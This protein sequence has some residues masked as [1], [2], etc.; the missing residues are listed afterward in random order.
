[1]D[2]RKKRLPI[3][4]KRIHELPPDTT[5]VPTLS[6]IKKMAQ[7][8][9]IPKGPWVRGRLVDE[10]DGTTVLKM[11][12]RT[13]QDCDG[14]HFYGVSEPI[15]EGRRTYRTIDIKNATRSCWHNVTDVTV[16]RRK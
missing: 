6:Q 5:P 12:C 2:M 16:R 1:M 8:P 14:T 10:L 3:N 13:G 4:R 7:R 9:R 15:H 11:Y